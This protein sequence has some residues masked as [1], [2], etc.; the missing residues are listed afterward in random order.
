MAWLD[1]VTLHTTDVS[2]W[3]ET[4]YRVFGGSVDTYTRLHKLTTEQCPEV[5]EAVAEAYVGDNPAV[6]VPYDAGTYV[7]SCRAVRSNAA[8]G[9]IV[10]KESETLGAWVYVEPPE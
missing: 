8:G 9:F 5:T 3:N 6:A 1:T 2:S 10:T 4:Q 7:K